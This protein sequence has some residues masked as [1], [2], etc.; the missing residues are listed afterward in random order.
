[1]KFS[2]FLLA[3]KNSFLTQISVIDIKLEI[4]LP[5]DRDRLKCIQKFKV[6][7]SITFLFLQLLCHLFEKYIF[8]ELKGKEFSQGLFLTLFVFLEKKYDQN[9]HGQSNGIYQYIFGNFLF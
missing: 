5:L 6:F 7:F 8:S 2:P 4:I 1:M 3:I 9:I